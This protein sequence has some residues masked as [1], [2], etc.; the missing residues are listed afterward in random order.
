MGNAKKNKKHLNISK[1]ALSLVKFQQIYN[2]GEAGA[3]R[4]KNLAK[5]LIK[6]YSQF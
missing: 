6:N 5:D 4:I 2:Y 3:E 1:F